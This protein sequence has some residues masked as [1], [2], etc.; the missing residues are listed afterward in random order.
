MP[1]EDVRGVAHYYEWVTAEVNQ[2]TG[3]P[4]LVFL[5]GWGGSCRYWRSTAQALTDQFDCLLYDLRGFGRSRLA[6]GAGQDYR[7]ET[8]AE[9]LAR[10]LDQLKTGPVQMSAHSMGSSIATLFAAQNSGAVERLVLTCGGVF[11]YEPQAFATFQRFGSGVVKFRPRW[12]TQIPL[13]DRLFMA[14]FLHQSLPSVESQAFLADFVAADA[15]A[16]LG[17]LRDSVSEA[18]AESLPAAF[19]ALSIPTLLISGQY[20]RIIPPRLGQ[21]AVVLNRAIAYQEIPATGHFPMLESPQVY[22]TVLREFLL[23]D[24]SLTVGSRDMPATTV[25]FGKKCIEQPIEPTNG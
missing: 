7:L 5:H 3:R 25:A 23:P 22:Q 6:A 13:L 4:V 2:P 8:Y 12:L 21:Q 14:R 19:S 11:E 18:M 17:T 20:D 15:A 24:G 16:A 10:F 1:F 9:D